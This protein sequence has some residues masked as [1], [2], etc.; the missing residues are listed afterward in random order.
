MLKYSDININKLEI[1]GFINKHTIRVFYF[2]Y[3]KI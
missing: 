3:K 1:L 2:K